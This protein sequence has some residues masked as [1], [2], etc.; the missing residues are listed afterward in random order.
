MP[1]EHEIDDLG[2]EPQ[3]MTQ[4]NLDNYHDLLDMHPPQ[5][6]GTRFA[7][8]SVPST[9]TP[10][11]ISQPSEIKNAEPDKPTRVADATVDSEPD[12]VREDLGYRSYTRAELNQIRG[13]HHVTDIKASLQPRTEFSKPPTAPTG[14][15]DLTGV[16]K[17]PT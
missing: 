5:V 8:S 12:S 2:P 10:G 4:R 9:E 6:A 1:A 13:Q 7:E 15:P 17:W 16:P 3:F 11:L 14:K